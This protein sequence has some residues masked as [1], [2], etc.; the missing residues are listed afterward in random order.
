MD[1]RHVAMITAMMAN[2]EMAPTINETTIDSSRTFRIKEAGVFNEMFSEGS[3]STKR[4]T[5]SAPSQ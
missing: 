1:L 4:K 5:E 2:Q 3:V